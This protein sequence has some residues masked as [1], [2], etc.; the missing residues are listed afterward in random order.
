MRVLAIKTAGLRSDLNDRSNQSIRRHVKDTIRE[1][2]MRHDDA[3]AALNAVPSAGLVAGPTPVEEMGRLRAALGGGP[4]LLVKRDDALPFGFGGNKVRKLDLVAARARSE[5]ADTLLTIGGVQSNHARATAA[6][7]ARLGLRCVLILNGARPDRPTGNALLDGLLGADIE[8]VSS[9]AERVPAMR[10]AADRLRAQGARPFEIPL[11]ASTPLGAMA[12]ARAMAELVA[13]VR[14]PDVIVHATS[15]GG[16]QAGLL[17]GCALLDLPTRVLGI[18]ADDPASVL[19]EV[20]DDLVSG[21]DAALGTGGRLRASAP[22]ATV[23]DSFVGE[24]YGIPTPASREALEVAARTEA[25]FLDSTYTAKAMAGLMAHVRAGRFRSDET[26]LFWHTGG[27]VGL[28][29]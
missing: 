11:G 21:I 22:R 13:Q 20:V 16:T 2:P 18:S 7:A 27:Q 17:A 14:P 19:G 29:A 10:A 23:D 6:A 9:R 3:V 26:V 5:G 8:Y 25:L 4:R 12:Y 28:L 1:E 24:G 15:S